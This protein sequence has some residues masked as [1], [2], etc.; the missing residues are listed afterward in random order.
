MNSEEIGGYSCFVQ[1]G[2]TYD[3]GWNGQR[4]RSGHTETRPQ[5]QTLVLCCVRLRRCLSVT[6]SR[7]GWFQAA[8]VGLARGSGGA[9]ASI[10]RADGRSPGAVRGGRG[11]SLALFVGG[12]RRR[13]RAFLDE[14]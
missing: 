5:R 1:I 2:G 11:R 4:Q 7:R 8:R 10:G 13:R 3:F 14:K 9:P 12:S 6:E